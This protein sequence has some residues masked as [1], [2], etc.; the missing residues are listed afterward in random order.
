MDALNRR[1]QAFLLF[2]CLCGIAAALASSRLPISDGWELGAFLLLS[3]VVGRTK[4]RLTPARTSQQ[5]TDAVGS[6][7]LSFVL[8]FVTLLHL[9][10]GA[11]MLVG[12]FSTLSSCL[13]PR[14]YSLHRIAFNV[15]LNAVG[16]YVA[17]C[18]FVGLH[19]GLHGAELH[20][21]GLL[22]L[23]GAVMA[24]CLSFFLINS[25]AVAAMIGLTTGRAMLTVWRESFLCTAPSY[26]AAGSAGT[27][28]GLLLGPQFGAVALFVG[29]VAALTYVVY[30]LSLRRSDE[31]QKRIDELQAQEMQLADALRHEH[32]IA[33]TLQRSL[34]S[35]PEAQTF[36]GLD[37]HTEYEAA[38]A[39]A[40]IGGDFYDTLPLPGGRV[41]L[42]V[43]DVAGKGLSAATHTAEVKYALRAILHDSPDPGAALARLND[44][45][46]QSRPARPG[47]SSVLV[48]V[49]LAVVDTRTGE[50]L[51]SL[52]GAEPPLLLRA[53]GE[54][55]ELTAGGMLLGVTHGEV[56]D[57]R[58][59]QLADSDSLLMVTDG[60][61]EARRGAEFF[62]HDGLRA[63][64][65]RVL[66]PSG[67][68]TIS[69]LPAGQAIIAEARRFTGGLLHDDVC[70]L[71]VRRAPV[72]PPALPAPLVYSTG[73]ANLAEAGPTEACSA[74][75]SMC[76]VL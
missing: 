70:L 39:E 63:A 1:A 41:A 12:F 59:V 73:E 58:R 48:A 37:V 67:N 2:V 35:A 56:Y 21:T 50:A 51:V 46:I 71:L 22:V 38:W 30:T 65:R 57:V 14:R 44:Y 15:G 68:S 72:S 66:M 69:V 40:L 17:G 53:G 18:V 8:I 20:G 4:V 32:L 42:V 27:L 54:A 43:G 25:L 31:N 36:A 47:E 62:G 6:L 9:G 74:V 61:T 11:A 75:R 16:T 19:G 28:A 49:A 52:A 33:E 55:E 26:F 23:F 7:S 60:L 64:A 34:L 24:S 45:L 76:G 29:P 10:P 5:T 3:L 13:Y